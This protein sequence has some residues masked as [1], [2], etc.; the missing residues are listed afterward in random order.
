RAKAQLAESQERS[1]QLLG[2]AEERLGQIRVE[3]ESVAGY[4]QNLRGMLAQAERVAADHGF[5]MEQA[6]EPAAAAASAAE[7][8]GSAEDGDADAGDVDEETLERE[9]AS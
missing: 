8:S 4:L 9:H 2:D 3:R 1:A 7:P 5:P 6:D